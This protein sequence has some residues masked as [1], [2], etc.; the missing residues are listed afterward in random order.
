MLKRIP[1]HIVDNDSSARHS[2][3]YRLRGLGHSVRCWHSGQSFLEDVRDHSAALVL[4]DMWMPDM[5]GLTILS[6]LHAAGITM[7][8]AVLTG[9]GNIPLAVRALKAGAFDFIEKPVGDDRLIELIDSA[10]AWLAENGH[11]LEMEQAAT[12]QLAALTIREREVLDGLVAGHTNKSVAE[13]L[14]ISKR[15]VEVHRAH[16]MTKL[17]VDTFADVLRIAF[18]AGLGRAARPGVPAFARAG[19][20][21]GA[22]L[23]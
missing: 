14:G 5:D 1:I 22:A 10:S 4:L 3:S 11:M 7:P 12:A 19:R 18:A 8:V 9:Q 6:E 2:L 15:T 21:A 16:L 23:H 17:T 20:P 13:K